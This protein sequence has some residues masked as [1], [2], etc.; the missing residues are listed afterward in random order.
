MVSATAWLVELGELASLKRSDVESVRNFITRK[1]DAIRLPYGRV[2]KNMPRRCV[3]LG[4]TNSRQ[5]LTDPEGNRRFWPVSVGTI[6]TVGLAK[7]RDQMWA[8][9]LHEFES[10]AQWWLTPEEMVKAKSEAS[11]YE[12]EDITQS[13]ILGWLDEQKKWPE[14]MFASDVATKIL[15]MTPGQISAQ[16]IA[17]I[18][19][20][21]NSMGWKRG[22]KRKAGIPT[23]GYHVPSRT[24]MKLDGD[25]LDAAHPMD[26]VITESEIDE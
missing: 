25:A 24:K 20:T 26:K 13:E 17:G 3:F 22:R 8:E 16:M 19:R 2:V 5:P 4:T 11:V 21:M 18:N 12:A 7:V 14:F 1:E 6:D 9:A 10:G 23:Y 15:R